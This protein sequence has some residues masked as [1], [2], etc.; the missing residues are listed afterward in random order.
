MLQIRHSAAVV[1]AAANKIDL[2]LIVR[3]HD[4]RGLVDLLQA[5]F[6][7]L[8]R[9]IMSAEMLHRIV[10]A[11]AEGHAVAVLRAVLMEAALAMIGAVFPA[12]KI[13][14]ITAADAL[15][16]CKLSDLL[17]RLH[18]LPQIFAVHHA[19]QML[20]RRIFRDHTERAM[21]RVDQCLWRVRHLPPCL[22]Q[23]EQRHF[24]IPVKTLRVVG[25]ADLVAD[26]HHVD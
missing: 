18:D 19:G 9:R 15:L 6:Q 23:A 26:G 4:G 25:Q 3:R 1:T 13:G 5:A 22:H 14:L 8:L 2:T 24:L 10:S 12:V 11:R 7:L 16:Q 17:E 21:C 20:D